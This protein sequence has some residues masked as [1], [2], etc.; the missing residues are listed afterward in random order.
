VAII[1]IFSGELLMRGVG[2][3][4]V[5][6]KLRIS[7]KLLSVAL[8]MALLLAAAPLPES[9][10][11]TVGDFAVLVASQIGPGEEP[12]K[13]QLTPQAAAARLQKAGIKLRQDLTSPV[14]EGDAVGVFGQLGIS[15][16]AQDPERLL[17][18]ERASSLIGIFGASLATKVGSTSSEGPEE[19]RADSRS[20]TQPAVFLDSILDCQNLPKTQDCNLCCRNLLGGSQNEFHSNRICGKA[21]NAKARNVSAT[22]PTP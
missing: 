5:G 10:S 19:I 22:E 15:L 12:S 4:V 8:G 14:T 13:S 20:A 18:R 6:A 21:C 9:K 11:L 7:L 16:Q 3:S 17:D 1:A 2:K